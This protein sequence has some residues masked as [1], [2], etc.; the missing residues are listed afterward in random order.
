MPLEVHLLLTGAAISGTSGC[1]AGI[2]AAATVVTVAVHQLR[3]SHTLHTLLSHSF[4]DYRV[5]T[6]QDMSYNTLHAHPPVAL[7]PINEI[8]RISQELRRGGGVKTNRNYMTNYS[9]RNSTKNGGLT[10]TNT[11]TVSYYLLYQHSTQCDSLLHCNTECSNALTVDH[12]L[13]I[14][15]NSSCATL[16]FALCSATKAAKVSRL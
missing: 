10:G 13:L 7:A 3:L 12:E 11:T 9:S 15:A 5:L 8:R 2:A 1:T 14:I 4:T 6:T 16:D